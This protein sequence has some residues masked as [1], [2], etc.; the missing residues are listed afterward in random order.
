MAKINWD[1]YKKFKKEHSNLK[2]CDN[3]E[4]VLEFLRSYYNRTSAFD[5]FDMLSADEL[6][7]MMLEKRDITQPEHLEDALY[8]RLTR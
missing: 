6:G 5:V 3:F 8:K 7:K 1:E 2:E 4:I